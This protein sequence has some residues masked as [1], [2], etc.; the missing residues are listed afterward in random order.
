MPAGKLTLAVKATKKP[1]RRKYKLHKYLGMVP[2]SG[3]AARPNANYIPDKNYMKL[4]YSDCYHGTTSMSSNYLAGIQFKLNSAY[5]VQ[6]TL[7]AVS[8]QSGSGG[9][10]PYAW[11]TIKTLYEWCHVYKVKITIRC[12]HSNYTATV[13]R[14]CANNGTP[15]TNFTLECERPRA[16]KVV[17]SGNGDSRTIK[18]TFNIPKILGV[19]LSEYLGDDDYGQDTT[20]N[21]NPV[22]VAYA[23]VLSQAIDLSNHDAKYIVDMVLFCKFRARSQLSQS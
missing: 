7:T 20:S 15:P 22:K 10:Q 18:K 19:S 17:T 8:N 23:N 6:G 21:V 13:L 4:K 9:H 3:T 14:D 1:G 12:M 5:D 11:D 16:S 2:A